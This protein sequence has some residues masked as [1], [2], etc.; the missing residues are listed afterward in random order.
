[1][2]STEGEKRGKLKGETVQPIS[3]SYVK[4]TG[5]V[6][7][8]LKTGETGIAIIF[9]WPH[10]PSAAG[11]FGSFPESL[12]APGRDKSKLITIPNGQDHYTAQNGDI[13]DKL[14]FARSY[15]IL[16]IPVFRWWVC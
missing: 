1:M 13:K 15:A 7:A 8:R 14:A 12:A 6:P 5:G 11:S 4:Y 9:R 2:V 16:D 3:S 10:P